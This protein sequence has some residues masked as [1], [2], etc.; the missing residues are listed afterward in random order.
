MK[1][2]KYNISSQIKDNL[3]ALGFIRPTDIQYKAIP[4]LFLL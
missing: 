1:F 4:M 3:D 2:S